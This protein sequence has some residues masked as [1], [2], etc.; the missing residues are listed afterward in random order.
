M[1]VRPDTERIVET[2]VSLLEAAGDAA[3]S[4]RA[5]L[6]DAL[7]LEQLPAE[8]A[9]A[10]VEPAVRG[11]LEGGP[12]AWHR[13]A[14]AVQSWLD[15]VLTTEGRAADPLY[16]AA[17]QLLSAFGDAARDAFLDPQRAPTQMD[18]LVRPLFERLSEALVDA[19]LKER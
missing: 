19:T 3:P 4:V 7:G 9:R 5:G 15:R 14:E 8:A 10:V 1:P 2:L 12:E 11:L 18:A 16:Q 17:M 13:A 6:A